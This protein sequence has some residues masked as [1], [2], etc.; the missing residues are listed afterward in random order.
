MNILRLIKDNLTYFR[1]ANFGIFLGAAAAAA[2]LTGALLTGDSITA[3]LKRINQSRL[4]QVKYA[5]PPGTSYFRTELATE[6]AESL[7]TTVAPI[8]RVEGIAIA[9]GG[10][11][12]A[13]RVKITGVNPAFFD[14]SPNDNATYKPPANGV[15]INEK[16]ASRIG[17]AKGD[18]LLLRIEKPA[19]LPRDAPLS[20]DTDT[21][22][23]LRTEVADVIGIN[24]FG[25]FNLEA[26]QISPLNVFVP[27]DTLAELLD[28]QDLANCLLIGGIENS[29][30]PMK[31]VQA[32]LGKSWK[33]E[34][35]GLKLTTIT[36]TNNADTVELRSSSVFINPYI[37]KT[38]TNIAPGAQGIF[39]YFV[40]ELKSG[41]NSAPYSFVSAPGTSIIPEG[42]DNDEII[43]NHWL[44][45]D[46]GASPGD[47]LTLKYFVLGPL[48]A[49]EEEQASFTIHSITPI[50]GAAADSSLMPDFPGLAGEENCRDW[51]PGVP[52]DLDRIRDKDEAYWDKYGGLPKAFV[53]LDSAQRMWGNKFGKLTAVRFENI[54]R[55]KLSARIK[56]A[57]DPSETGLQFINISEIGQR[58]AA[59][60]VDFHQLFVGLSFFLVLSALLLTALLFAFN[61][62]KRADQ[63]GLLRAIGFSPRLVRTILLGEGAIIALTASVFGAIIGLFYTKL[64]IQAL[65]TVWQGVVSTPDLVFAA[66]TKSFAIGIAS[67][68]IASMIS[69]FLVTRHQGAKT[70]RALQQEA[71]AP[72]SVTGGTKRAGASLYISIICALAA[73]AVIALINPGRGRQAAGAFFGAGTLLLISGISATRY[74]L[75]RSLTKPSTGMDSVLSLAFKNLS[76][77]RN[78][79]LAAVGLLACGVFLVT[80]VSANRKS[81]T[82]ATQDRQSGTGGFEFFA[83]TTIPVIYDLNTDHG[84]SY[85]G[86]D[87]SLFTNTT[88]VQMKL[89]EGDDASCLNLNRA[90]TPQLLGAP[91]GQL[92]QMEAFQFAKLPEDADMTNPWSLLK[93]DFGENIVPGVV[94][95]SVLT[96]GLHKSIGD[97]ITYTGENGEPFEIKIACA[98]VD[99]VFQGN[100]LISRD[101]FTERFPSIPGTRVLLVDAPSDKTG[102]VADAL[103]YAMADSGIDLA[104]ASNRLAEFNKVQNTYL[105]IFLIL[106][107]LA[108]ILGSIGLGIVVL[109]NILE[110]K[111]EL[112]VMRAFGFEHSTVFKI[113]F[114]EHFF[115]LAAGLLVG[116]IAALV[117]IIPSILS[118]GMS[119]PYGIL[120][121]VFGLVVINGIAWTYFSTALGLKMNLLSALREE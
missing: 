80:A 15:F 46:I 112:A 1:G 95:Q 38:V 107:A 113:V 39:T 35:A 58:A 60:S 6:L 23:T 9:E 100:I 3:S 19:L 45:D 84:R 77:R 74:I 92:E 17:I 30:Q 111:N 116:L 91:A 82:K 105:S 89:R 27:L 8:I 59:Q 86:L 67:A 61:I 21:T 22:A 29:S 18:S 83:Q 78:R 55:E 56:S 90:Q 32:A 4:G 16:L 52:I 62:E 102:A 99:S 118:P 69:I 37:E 117:S 71:G 103:S 88:F 110:R 76:R 115:I 47:S 12:R 53:T 106:G 50:E 26:E 108:I 85:Y 40:N 104:P 10:N 51:T 101:A 79:T 96:W 87:D 48:R 44:A 97:T 43:I 57:L 49:I 119:V 64:I 13:N 42:I 14:L 11:R 54:T 98:L 25:R 65:K 66:N 24:D 109:R 72:E 20:S 31:T 2:V 68:F 63:T 33:L 94:D 75:F 5:I 93:K 114:T 121:P 28:K 70:I 36:N 81:P 7:N 41:T 73:I 120:L 34:D